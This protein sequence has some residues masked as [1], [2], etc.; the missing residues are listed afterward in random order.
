MS[1]FSLPHFL[2]NI[3]AAFRTGLR[4]ASYDQIDLRSKIYRYCGEIEELS[5]APVSIELSI[6]YSCSDQ[7]SIGRR[8]RTVTTA[9]AIT[10]SHP[11]PLGPV[12]G[13]E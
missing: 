13:K 12:E 9:Y 6:H 2:V 3:S 5:K 11:Q 8:R 7:R 4:I 1:I 10:T